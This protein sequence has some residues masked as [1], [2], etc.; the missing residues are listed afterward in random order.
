MKLSRMD[1]VLAFQSQLCGVMETVLKAAVCEITRLVEDSFL[2]EVAQSRQEAETLR[3]R[4]RWCES[5]R[6]ERAADGKTRCVECGRAGGGG[7]PAEYR[8][9]V[10]VH[11]CIAGA[12]E[13]S[14]LHAD[15]RLHVEDSS[16]S[17]RMNTHTPSGSVTDQQRGKQYAGESGEQDDAQAGHEGV[18]MRLGQPGALHCAGAS[19]D[20]DSKDVSWTSFKLGDS[21][22]DADG[23]ESSHAESPGDHTKEPWSAPSEGSSK[24]GSSQ[25]RVSVKAETELSSIVPVKEEV[26]MAPLWRDQI[27][28]EVTHRQI[29]PLCHRADIQIDRVISLAS[30]QNVIKSQKLDTNLAARQ[31]G[32]RTANTQSGV[33]SAENTNGSNSELL[34]KDGGCTSAPSFRASR[35]II[36]A[37]SVCWREKPFVCRQCGKTFTRLKNL[38]AHVKQHSGV[39]PHSCTHCGRSFLYLSRLKVHLRSHTGERP[40]PCSQCGK[41]FLSSYDLKVHQRNH[42][43]EK[44]YS[45]AQCGKGFT[46]LSILKEHRSIHTKERFS[47]TQCGKRFTRLS[48][49]KTHLRH[50]S[51]RNP[52]SCTQCGKT[53]LFFCRLQK[54]QKKIHGQ[55]Q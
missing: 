41:S 45:C 18:S 51:T 40:F 47:C 48:N 49:M 15:M 14:L 52:Y 20:L 46:R 38:Q 1:A 36:S 24:M 54:H 23:L 13:A 30:S 32:Q 6:R 17:E 26:D 9:A 28:S 2:A 21:D 7:A 53:F 8:P 16:S 3:Q 11:V 5:K 22:S 42:T 25:R 10:A 44:P 34:A 27:Q 50:H 4:L 39:R 33:S 37:P 31:H 29:R 43:G 19:H 12:E 35:S 55:Q